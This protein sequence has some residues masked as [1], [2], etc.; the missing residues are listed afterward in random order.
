MA[1]ESDPYDDARAAWEMSA[2]GISALEFR[3]WRSHRDSAKRR[4]IAFRFSLLRWWLWWRS[5]IRKLPEGAARG[6]RRHEY[7]MARRGD[8][9]AYEPGNVDCVTAS[10]NVQAIDR[11][12]ISAGM[13]ASHARRKAAGIPSHLGVRGAAHPRSRGVVTP[14]GVFGSAALAGEAHGFTRQHAARLAGAG[15]GGWRWTD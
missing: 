12:T 7:V 14:L 9:G 6:R 8:A 3:A 13:V 2:Y 10:A 5:E 4:G 1:Y 11:A 15:R